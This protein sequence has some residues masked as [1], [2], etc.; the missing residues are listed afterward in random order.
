MKRALIVSPYYPPS[1]LAGVHRARYLARYLPEF[2][3]TPTI[4]CVDERYH[5]ETLDPQLGTLAECAAKI[6]KCP[7][8]PSALARPFGFGDI[9]L[10]GYFG[11]RRAVSNFLKSQK[12][13]LLFITAGP[14]YTA[15]L[16]P[17]FKRRHGLPYVVDFQDPW[18]SRWGATLPRWS[19]GGLSH[20]IAESLEPDVVRKADAVVSVSEG[21]N[22]E[23][24]ARYPWLA[25]RRTAAIPIGGDAR[26]FEYLARNPPAHRQVALGDSMANLCYVG[27]VLP[28]AGPVVDTLLR[29]IAHLRERHPDVLANVRFH[30]VG[31][32]NQPDGREAYAVRDRA[33]AAGIGDLVVETPQRVSYLEALSILGGARGILLIGSDEPHYTASKIYPGILSGRPLLG[34]FHRAS[35]AAQVLRACGNALVYDFSGHDELN[36]L[37]ST[38]AAGLKQLLLRR[39]PL[40]PPNPD[41]FAPYTAQR[42]TRCFAELFDDILRA[43]PAQ[44]A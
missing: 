22:E 5:E 28:R 37:V 21:A 6:V 16:G 1:T 9:S 7:A 35:S 24:R 17:Y 34:L 3:W 26:D 44:Q 39:E 27:T 12:A 14:F 31:T 10:R 4:F 23:L 8:I 20:R 43:G 15:L 41:G 2:G 38:V 25:G 42:T 36:A 33:R 13:D 11:V 30:F 18:V 29:A 32:S 19:K 40:P